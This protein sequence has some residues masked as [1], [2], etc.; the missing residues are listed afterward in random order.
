M[1][2][3]CSSRAP[4]PGEKL[5]H[6]SKND[7]LDNIRFDAVLLKHRV[8]QKDRVEREVGGGTGMENTCKPMAVSFQC[9]TKSTT[10]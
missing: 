10:I 8:K 7:G 3:F 1:S 9:M 5:A 6:L 4:E 2:Y